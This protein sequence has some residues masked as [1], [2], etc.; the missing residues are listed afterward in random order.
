M[1]NPLSR[2]RW[3]RR[4]K[5]WYRRPF[6]RRRLARVQLR[7]VSEARL[8]AARVGVILPTFNRLHF[9]RVG[10]PSLLAATRDIDC[11]FLFWDNASADG[12]GAWLA[13]LEDPRVT[14]VRHPEN[15]GI[16]ALARSARQVSGD[17]L[18]QVDDDV[19]HFPDGFL[20]RLVRAYLSIPDMGYL[21]PAVVQDEF[22]DGCRPPLWRSVSVEHGPRLEVAYGAVGGWCTLT[23][24]SLYDELGGFL[25]L[26]GKTYFWA[27]RDYYRKVEARGLKRGIFEGDQ[28]YHAYRVALRSDEAPAFA[29]KREDLGDEVPPPPPVAEG[30]WERFYQRYP[31]AARP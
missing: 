1:S 23:E 5:R 27:D 9:L 22:T 4:F 28:V 25:E 8:D 29:A 14:V 11:R 2:A 18:L 31:E 24:R 26:P 12:S 10:V 21:A 30:F 6:R 7:E 16:N 13:G 20:R 3:Y 17:F 15:I 19:I